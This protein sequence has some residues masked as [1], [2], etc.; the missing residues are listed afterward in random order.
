LQDKLNM[1]IRIPFTETKSTR[2]GNEILVTGG[3]G[4]IGS[5]TIVQLTLAGFKPI[6]LDNLSNSELSVLH[7]LNYIL[8]HETPFYL[9]DCNDKNILIDIFSKHPQISGVIHFAAHKAVGESVL[10]PLKYYHNNIHSLVTLLET[11]GEFGVKD[12]VFSSSC[13][14]YGQPETLPV[15]ELTPIKKAESPY[16]NTKQISEE[17][18]IDTVHSG[19]AIR[20]VSLRYFNPI[21]AHPSA[22]IGE[23]PNGLP[24]NLVPFVTQTAIGKREKLSVFGNDYNTPDGTCVRDF[25]HVV[26]LA[27][28]HIAAFRYLG[29]QPENEAFYDVFNIGAGQ[30]S[31]VLEVI[32]TFESATGVKFN[33][34][35]APRRTGDVEKIY[36]DVSKANSLLNWKVQFSLKDSLIHAWNWEKKLASQN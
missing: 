23:L 11:M 35:F 31:S 22:H 2:Q 26:D 10:K 32:N 1:E 6:I 36:A 5:H 29:H 4:F 27:D 12:I 24:N 16:G 30:G 19:S 3:T 13:T 7:G 17:I 20:V 18:L 28:A 34:N 15:T 33:W 9:G 21:G 8:G 14:V 25:I